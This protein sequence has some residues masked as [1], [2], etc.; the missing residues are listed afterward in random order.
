AV[1]A[2]LGGHTALHSLF[3]Y[4]SLDLTPTSS[5]LRNPH[6]GPFGLSDEDEADAEGSSHPHPRLRQRRQKKKKNIDSADAKR[7]EESK[8]ELTQL[9]EEDKLARVPLLVFA[10]KQDLMGAIPPDQISDILELTRIRDR[11]WQIQPCSA[12]TGAGL[13]GGLDWVVGMVKK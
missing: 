12:K 10:N 7:V 9:L 6:H 11:P 1:E 4:F 8:A 2:L 3:R 5:P 13:E